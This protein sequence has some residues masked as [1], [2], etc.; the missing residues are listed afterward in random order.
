MYK[1]F[2][3]FDGN[4]KDRSNN[5][6]KHQAQKNKNTANLVIIRLLQKNHKGREYIHSYRGKH[7]HTLSVE[8]RG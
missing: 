8:G 6:N 5:V 7:T 2:S 3:K 1:N 4:N